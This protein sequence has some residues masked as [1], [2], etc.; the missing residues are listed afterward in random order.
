[1]KLLAM[2]TAASA[3]SAALWDE[4]VVVERL[5]PMS[6]GHSEALLP[7]I[8]DVMGAADLN[9]CDL[10]ALAVSTGPGAF[11]GLRVGLAAARGVGLAAGLPCLGVS[12]LEAIAEAVD[13]SEVGDSTVLI[14]LDTKRDDYYVQ[15]FRA[16]RPL[17]SPVVETRSN[18]A[19]AF[20]GQRLLLA[21]DASETL[22][23]ALTASDIGVDVLDIPRHSTAGRIAVL[24]AARWCS[25]E[26][27]RTPPSPV[28][29]RS[30]ATSGPCPGR[31]GCLPEA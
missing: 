27:P 16:S 20:A 19:L 10:D 1:V 15:V 28:Y 8:L 25:G 22:A 23:A 26:R 30:A 17:G 14:A 21:G 24:A 12:T 5:Q 11:T 9:F 4:G 6:R 18:L 31:L 13:W 2:D 3:C 29:L 7:M